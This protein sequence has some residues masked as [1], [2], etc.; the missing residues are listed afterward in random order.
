MTRFVVPVDEF[1]VGYFVGFVDK[2]PWY[3]MLR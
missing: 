3:Q 2:R 1:L